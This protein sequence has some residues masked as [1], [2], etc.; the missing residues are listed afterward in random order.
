MFSSL[1]RIVVSVVVVVVIVVLLAVII[2]A[3]SRTT[4]VSWRASPPIQ[5]GFP[6]SGIT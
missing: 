5:L 1:S 2:V 4:S 6:S 3:V